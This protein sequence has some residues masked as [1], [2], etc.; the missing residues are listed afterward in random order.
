[1]K[2]VFA[3]A[4]LLVLLIFYGC[5]ENTD[6][7]RPTD[8]ESIS[9]A[10]Q[11]TAPNSDTKSEGLQ[12]SGGFNYSYSETTPL[13]YSGDELVMNVRMNISNLSD[14]DM[15]VYLN[16]QGYFLPFSLQEYSDESFK[17]PV[18]KESESGNFH[19][20]NFSESDCRENRNRYFSVK[21]NPDMF[22]KGSTI[23]PDVV[24][25][26]NNT[27]LPDADG[28]VNISAS[29]IFGIY[30]PTLKINVDARQEYK[31]C[32]EY[33]TNPMTSENSDE[34][35]NENIK[36][37]ILKNGDDSFQYL[38]KADKGDSI[39][40]TARIHNVYSDYLEYEP[41]EAVV[42]VLVNDKPCA[43]FNGSEYLKMTVEQNTYYTYDFT[44]DTDDLNEMNK[45]QIYVCQLK[46]TAENPYNTIA[47][48][49]PLFVQIEE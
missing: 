1:M 19:Q 24:C 45:V 44:L 13:E 47:V 8:D 37:E 36:A 22:K 17:K 23:Y 3:A 43:V 40:L 30:P 7:I 42:S 27:Y 32:R 21:F 18:S 25:S 49:S 20:L 2:K 35:E 6:I 39:K 41:Q 28:T 10:V 12:M 34:F 4:L 29:N 14:T 9:D 31:V 15:G 16:V 48:S 26:V 11:T 33:S 5:S 46:G 38:V